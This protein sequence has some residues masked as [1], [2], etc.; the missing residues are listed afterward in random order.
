MPS[1]NRGVPLP[2]STRHGMHEY[3]TCCGYLMNGRH[4]RLAFLSVSREIS[5]T[6]LA[7]ARSGTILGFGAPGVKY[8]AEEHLGLLE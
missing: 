6:T 3:E 4:S 2:L 5:L 1:S 7:L 8:Q